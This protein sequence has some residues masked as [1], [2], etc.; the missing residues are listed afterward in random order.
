MRFGKLFI[1]LTALILSHSLMGQSDTIDLV[2]RA[3]FFFRSVYGGGDMAIIENLASA[4]IAA[5]YPIFEQIF[6]KKV[7][8]G[9]EAYKQ[10]AIGFNSR[11]KNC[12]VTI[13]E[14]IN[15]GDKVV[16][17]WSFSANRVNENDQ[18]NISEQKQNWGGITLFRFD[19]SGKIIQEL[20]E[21]STPGPYGRLK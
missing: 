20:G 12:H 16:L 4:E 18:N 13:D 6:D 7:I 19:D 9:K 11:W 1:L 15:Q 5:S 21:E 2:K 10:F 3:E 8:H 14:A 17:I